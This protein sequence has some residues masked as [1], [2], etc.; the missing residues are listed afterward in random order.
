MKPMLLVL[1]VVVLTASYSLPALAQLEEV[2]VR[3]DGLSCPFCAHSLEKRLRDMDGVQEV[4]ISL[5]DGLASLTPVPGESIAIESLPEVVK[6]AGFTSREIRV[7][8]VGHLKMEEGAAWLVGPDG[9][10]FRLSDE[11]GV[12]A[13]IESAEGLDYE[14]QGV[15]AEGGKGEASKDGIALAVESITPRVLTRE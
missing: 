3:V 12:L 14:V 6:K 9:P 11:D 1:V 10:L 2:A 15:V 4:V 5:K 8:V 13:S 7:R